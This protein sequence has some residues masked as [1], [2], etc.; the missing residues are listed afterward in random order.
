MFIFANRCGF[1]FSLCKN[2][3]WRCCSRGGVSALQAQSP[4]FNPRCHT[5]THTHTHNLFDQIVEKVVPF[6]L[7]QLQECSGK[8]GFVRVHGLLARLLG[9]VLLSKQ[10]WGQGE[11]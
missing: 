7:M 11:F 2:L 3:D 9:S 5:H 1:F 10:E 8:R 6:H 4:Q